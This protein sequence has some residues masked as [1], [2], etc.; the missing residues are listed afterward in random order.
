M[1]QFCLYLNAQNQKSDIVYV[2]YKTVKAVNDVITDLEP[3][4][5]KS[6]KMYTEAITDIE[7]QLYANDSIAVFEKKDK[8]K[9]ENIN[10]LS[11]LIANGVYY[12][13]SNSK[14]KIKHLEMF[15]E[16]FNVTYPF[17][18]YKWQITSESKMI[19]GYKCYKAITH[20]ESF[21]KSR[22]KTIVTNPIAWFSPEIPLN[23]G[24]FGLIGLPGLILEATLNGKIYYYATKIDLHYSDKAALKLEKP[25]KGKYV[26]EKE[27]EKIQLGIYDDKN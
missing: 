18:E 27:L 19:N 9:E 1:L 17:D 11:K 15:G 21:S 23:V 16:L 12:S 3:Q 24:P 8:L 22:N 5:K 14:E 25:S 7:F 2:E 13:N 6:L 4:L 26:T 20:K 10:P